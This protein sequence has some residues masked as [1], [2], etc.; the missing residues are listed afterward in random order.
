MLTDKRQT[1]RRAVGYVAM[2]CASVNLTEPLKPTAT[3][4]KK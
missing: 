1:L 2:H 4:Q 3:A